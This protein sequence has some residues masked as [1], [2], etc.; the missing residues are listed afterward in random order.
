LIFKFIL[1]G[2]CKQEKLCCKNCNGLAEKNLLC[3]LQNLTWL[4][5]IVTQVSITSLYFTVGA[6]IGVLVELAKRHVGKH[7][8]LFESLKITKIAIIRF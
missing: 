8:N 5:L 3:N 2:K 1:H 7:T 6:V 4:L